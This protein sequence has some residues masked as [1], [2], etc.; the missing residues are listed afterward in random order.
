MAR[1]NNNSVQDKQNSWSF[2]GFSS[3]VHEET[4]RFFSSRHKMN[5]HFMVFRQL[6]LKLARTTRIIL[7]F[8]T[9]KTNG[10]FMGF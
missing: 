2:H 4:N 5:G 3:R 10:H 7:L 8:K 1:P 6:V 9:N